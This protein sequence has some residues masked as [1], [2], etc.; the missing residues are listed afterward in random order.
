MTAQDGWYQI[1]LG[2]PA[3]GMFGFNTTFFYVSHPGYTDHSEI[4][5][6]GII[7]VARHDLG[8]GQRR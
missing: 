4:A 1:D 5:G 8:L 2:C 6:K 3:S 7:G